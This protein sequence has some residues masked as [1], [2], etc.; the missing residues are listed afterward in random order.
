[1]TPAELRDRTRVFAVAVTR[2]VK[3]LFTDIRTRHSASQLM[4]A[5]TSVAANYRATGLSRSRA[6]FISKLSVVVEEADE[7]VFWL[8]VLAD[9][10]PATAEIWSGLRSEAAQLVRIFAASR[11]TATTRA[12]QTAPTRPKSR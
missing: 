5:A 10:E 1:M 7:V 2:A 3:P 8:D 12:P 11:R 4:R 9:T 6:E